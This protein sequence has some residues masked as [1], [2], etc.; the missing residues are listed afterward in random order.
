LPIA[1]GWPFGQVNHR[2][3]PLSTPAS[4]NAFWTMYLRNAEKEEEE[5]DEEGGGGTP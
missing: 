5:E 3:A 1:N 4:I 2:F